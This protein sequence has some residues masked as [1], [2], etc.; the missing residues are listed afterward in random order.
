MAKKKSTANKNAVSSIRYEGQVTVEKVRGNKVVHKSV[1]KNTGC[2]PLFR[3][4]ATCLVSTTESAKSTGLF[5]SQPQYLDCFFQ[6]PSSQENGIDFGDSAS[7]KVK[8]YMKQI[9]MSVEQ[10]NVPANLDGQ[11]NTGYKVNIKFLLQDNN[12]TSSEAKINILALYDSNSVGHYSN[13]AIP[14]A[15][16]IIGNPNDYLDYV[17][18]VNYIITWSLTISN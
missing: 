15:Y 18:G 10:F 12:F 8:S 17:E 16:I 2:A 11:A 3:F 1:I 14:H 4:L 13:P 5:N 6:S 7:H 9:G